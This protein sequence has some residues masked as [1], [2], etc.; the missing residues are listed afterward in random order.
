M[1]DE[2]AVAHGEEVLRLGL[3]AEG[4]RADNVLVRECVQGLAAVAVPN[5]AS[6]YQLDPSSSGTGAMDARGKV[7][8]ASDCA[9]RVHAD[10]GRP[11]CALVACK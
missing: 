4:D 8:T 9:R 1:G 2:T 3:W 10:F 6:R 5:L 7:G 11:D